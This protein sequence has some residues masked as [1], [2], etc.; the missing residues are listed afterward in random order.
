MA[1][2][3]GVTHEKKAVMS[4]YFGQAV[5]GR[6]RGEDK[7]NDYSSM[8]F[9]IIPSPPLRS[10][11]PNLEGIVEGPGKMYNGLLNPLYSGKDCCRY[12][13]KNSLSN[14]A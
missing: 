9:K 12:A 3:L 8:I 14:Y 11:R 13:E 4:M 6:Y 10:F 5:P 1:T 2:D 7:E